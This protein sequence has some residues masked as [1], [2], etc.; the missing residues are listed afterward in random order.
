MTYRT[1]KLVEESVNSDL[2][3]IK[4]ESYSIS[5]L[6]QDWE[7][8]K[9]L[10]DDIKK[11]S[12]KLKQ[13]GSFHTRPLSECSKL[14]K[15]EKKLKID[16]SQG[17]EIKK[18]QD[19]CEEL[20]IIIVKHQK[21]K[22]D[23]INTN[24]QLKDDLQQAL[25]LNSILKK[26]ISS[27]CSTNIPKKA[28]EILK[29]GQFIIKKIKEVPKWEDMF[30]D[31]ISSVSTYLSMIKAQRFED[32]LLETLQFLSDLVV[33]YTKNEFSPTVPFSFSQDDENIIS[34]NCDESENLLMTINAQSERIAKLNKQISEAVLTSK[35]LLYSP[36]ATVGRRDSRSLRPTCFTPNPNGTKQIF[37]TPD[38]WRIGRESIEET[39][40]DEEVSGK[41]QGFGR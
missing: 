41:P 19:K 30:L 12:D 20:S 6:K 22:Q 1:D 29:Y 28:T 40:P 3:F 35:E 10:Q 2:S 23:L 18:L 34:N 37:S 16:T 9:L 32:C 33:S 26:Q 38:C 13:L 5:N 31:R 4:D 36:L 8:I 24:L 14:P 27:P 25:N 39:S 7:S 21:E 17:R 11:T 15:V